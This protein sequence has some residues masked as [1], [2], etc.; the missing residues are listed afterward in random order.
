M[1]GYIRHP[2]GRDVSPSRAL[3]GRGPWIRRSALC[4]P[5]E[6]GPVVEPGSDT[7][8]EP[9]THI[10]VDVVEGDIL[11][12]G[13]TSHPRFDRV[14]A[15]PVPEHDGRTLASAKPSVTPGEQDDRDTEEL[16]P[17]LRQE[18]L[19][20]GWVPLIRMAPEHAGGDEAA[21]AAR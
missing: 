7:T 1:W 6:P 12:A 4:A 19:L 15:G 11:T 10:E 3:D 5:G 9:G 20:P 2:D 16:G 8:G 17:H 14:A 13:S 21:Q 18:V